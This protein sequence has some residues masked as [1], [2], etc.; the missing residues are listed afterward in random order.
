M[1]RFIALLRAINVG[2]HTVKMDR[3]RQLFA[4]LGFSNV[5]TLIASGNV[6]FE[7]AARSAPALEK[8]IAHHLEESL[9]YAVVTF[10][11]SG[12]ELAAVARHRPFPSAELAAEGSALYVAFLPRPPS[13]EA[14]RKLMALRSEGDDFHVRGREAFWLRHGKMSESAFSPARLE[15]TLGMPATLRNVT[16]VRKLASRCPAPPR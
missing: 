5:E 10:I 3:L 12:A 8:K 1:P 7:S 16:T 14:K 2:G 6:L 15:K 4:E 13:A 9:G 11:R